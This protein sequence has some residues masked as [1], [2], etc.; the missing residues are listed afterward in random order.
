MT[1]QRG[2]EW[3]TVGPVPEGLV[4]VHDDAA[5]N[6]VVSRALDTG[7]PIPLIGLC[8]GDLFRAVG[9][10]DGDDRL[11]GGGDVAA[12]P[13]DVVR[14]VLDGER[15][16]WSTVHVVARRP[17]L[18]SAALG[19]W[20]GRVIGWMTAQYLG[21]WDV[22]PRSHP[23]DG[24]V[25]VV[26]VDAAMTVGDRRKA[27]A[28]LPLGTH[29]PHPHITVR[30]LRTGEWDLPAGTRVWVDGRP[31]GLARHV[32]VEVVPDAYVAHV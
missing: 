23:N 32:A 30:Q 22:A 17:L 4:R 6:D 31:V 15:T 9:G 25:D 24:R 29:M 28:R 11:A 13:C 19:W 5:L 21:T 26:T 12:L 20:R 10:V 8:G 3:G 14:V 7:A 2:A 27:R 1:I 16:L 18:G